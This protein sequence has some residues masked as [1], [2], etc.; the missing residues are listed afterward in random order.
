MIQRI[1]ALILL[2][3]S[4][5]IASAT[6][7]T[8]ELDNVR[9]DD[10]GAAYGW[11]EVDS[12]SGN[13]LG[14]NIRVEGGNVANFPARVYDASSGTAGQRLSYLAN[15]VDSFIFGGGDGDVQTILRL[16]PETNLEGQIGR[17]SLDLSF[18]DGNVECQECSPYR[19]IVDGSMV[20]LAF[21]DG[22]DGSPPGTG[23]GGDG[24]G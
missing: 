20:N 15:P 12:V 11:I 8:W 10:G 3:L 13:L 4:S 1:T 19:L 2:A 14:F 17:I 5:S 18:G 7:H 23:G 22:F 24:D 16:T 6:P 9:F 21:R